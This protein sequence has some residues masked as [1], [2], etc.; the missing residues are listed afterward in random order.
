MRVTSPAASATFSISAAPEWP[1]I[2]VVTDA[3]GPHTWT[4]TISWKSFSMS[5]VDNTPGSRNGRWVRTANVLCDSQAGNI[6]WDTNDPINLGR[7]EAELRRR[8]RGGYSAG[9]TATG[10]WKYF[11]VCYADSI[12]GG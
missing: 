5:G 4:W 2:E 11:G 9:P 10:H 12:L 1:T 6:G 3:A 8:D 7:S